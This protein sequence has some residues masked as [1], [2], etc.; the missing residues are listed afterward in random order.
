MAACQK[1]K[2]FFVAESCT[3]TNRGIRDFL[4]EQGGFE[5]AGFAFSKS[6]CIQ[7]IAGLSESKNFPDILIL[8]LSQQEDEDESGI[9]ALREIKKTYP[10]VKVLVHSMYG[11]PSIVSL[12]FEAGAEGFIQKSVSEREFLYAIEKI[13][14]GRTYLH[15]CLVP[16]FCA[17][18]KLFESLSRQEQVIFKMLV[19]R[20]ST[21]RMLEELNIVVRSLENHI[22][23]IYKKTC[24]K[25]HAEFNERFCMENRRVGVL[26]EH[27]LELPRSGE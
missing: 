12:A 26:E 17:Y 20:K 10:A 15:P 3:L 22:S 8:D 1:S 4:S 13:L 21:S 6:E 19:E 5:C 23:R 18:K 9:E 25:N 11:K 14:G 24:C 27:V 2:T 16:P 7:K